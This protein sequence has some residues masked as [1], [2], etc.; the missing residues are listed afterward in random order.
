MRLIQVPYDSGRKNFR[1]GNGP[2]HVVR[3]ALTSLGEFQVETIEVEEL[4]F[5][6]GTTL[7]ILS[8]LS[9]AVSA[10][11]SGG[12]FPL[13]LAG[14][15][16][17]SLGTLAGLG[18]RTGVVWLDAHGDFNT[19]ETTTSG[20]FDGMA[21]AT[22]TGRCWKNLTATIPGFRAVSED[23][24]ILIGA[25]DLDP[26]ERKLL[27][28]SAVTQIGTAAIRQRGVKDAVGTMLTRVKTDQIYLHIDLD[29]LDIGEA[30]VNLFSSTGGL[31]VSELIEIVSFLAEHK[32]IAAAAITAYD[33]SY[34]A[35]DNRAVRAAVLVIK[36][37]GEAQ[38]RRAGVE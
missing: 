9:H 18:Q 19:P 11:I 23:D 27:D 36:E 22:A 10:S 3:H 4:A 35:A 8:S 26:D 15:C 16:V 25:R 14:N 37:L 32:V 30:R 28:H 17:S 13:V 5:E 1:M 20:F 29:V 7:R 34:E 2:S 6:Q 31:R 33:P 38:L 24:V 12:E 21:L